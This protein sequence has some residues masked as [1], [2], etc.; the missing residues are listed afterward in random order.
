MVFDALIYRFSISISFEATEKHS[1]GNIPKG[2]SVNTKIKLNMGM[3]V[4]KKELAA[5]MNTF[6]KLLYL[7]FIQQ[8]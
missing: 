6:E 1:R 4:L 5:T 3:A 7:I 2:D 8:Y